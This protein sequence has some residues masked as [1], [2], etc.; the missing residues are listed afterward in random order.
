MIATKSAIP[1]MGSQ[2]VTR[3]PEMLKSRLKKL[4]LWSLIGLLSGVP[5][6]WAHRHCDLDQSELVAH[7][8]FYHKCNDATFSTTWHLHFLDPKLPLPEQDDEQDELP[9]FV[10]FN[11][12]DSEASRE[13]EHQNRVKSLGQHA[14]LTFDGSVTFGPA[15]GL[16][17]CYACQLTASHQ[18]RTSCKLHCTW[19]I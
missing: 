7:F 4:V 6:P 8:L 11:T 14:V 19:Q 15:H 1:Y 2:Q 5:L 9:N 10:Y 12:V 17:F 13:I 16:R 3:V 18:S